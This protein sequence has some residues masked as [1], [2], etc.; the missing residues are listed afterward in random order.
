MTFQP[1]RAAVISCALLTLSFGLDAAQ[2]KQA[3]TAASLKAGAETYRQCCAVCHGTAGKGD[4]PA[5]SALKVAPPDLSTLARRHDGRFPDAYV[6]EVVRNGVNVAAHGT[7]EM[8][9]WG[10]LFLA[11][12]SSFQSQTKLRIANL[13]NYIKSLQE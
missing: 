7:A 5:A 9:I 2:N 10:P 11:L 4:G 6:S 8:P 3:K 13:T 1:V 12:D